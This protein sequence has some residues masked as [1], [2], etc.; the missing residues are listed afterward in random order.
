[1]SKKNKQSKNGLYT[2]K[3]CTQVTGTFKKS[4]IHLETL[5]NDRVS[6]MTSNM[7]FDRMLRMLLPFIVNKS[8]EVLAAASK[9]PNLKP[10]QVHE[11]KETMYDTLNVAF[12]NALT[13]FAPDIEAR[14]DI[15]EDA[16]IRARNDILKEEMMKAGYL[17]PDGE[18]NKDYKPKE[19]KE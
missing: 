10:S 11:L 4:V 12:S 13:M 14:P 8:K 9:D 18:L 15:T 2:V 6:A 7:T 5:P 1:M 3:D 19:K 16:I 17:T